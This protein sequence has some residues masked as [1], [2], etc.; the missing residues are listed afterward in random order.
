MAFDTAFPNRQNVVTQKLEL[1]AFAVSR[2]IVLID[3]VPLTAT[4]SAIRS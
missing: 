4:T 2:S 1:E 3:L